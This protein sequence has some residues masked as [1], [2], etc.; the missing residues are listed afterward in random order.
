MAYENWHTTVMRKMK[1]KS[2]AELNYIIK[3][4]REAIES[5]GN[6]DPAK[7][8]KYADESHYAQMELNN[9]RQVA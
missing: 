4:C 9:R 2:V 3:D 6:L 5:L 7:C 1:S 8:G